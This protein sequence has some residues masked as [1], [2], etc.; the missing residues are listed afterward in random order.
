ERGIDEPESLERLVNEIDGVVDNGLF[1][2]LASRILVADGESVREW[3]P[4]TAGRAPRG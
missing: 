4:E 3:R 2:N 1:T